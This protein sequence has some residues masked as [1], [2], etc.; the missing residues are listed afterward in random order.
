MA[1][2]EHSKLEAALRQGLE[3]QVPDDVLKAGLVRVAELQ[4]EEQK[5][6]ADEKRARDEVIAAARAT[7]SHQ[8]KSS[9]LPRDGS[10]V[11]LCGLREGQGPC[12]YPPHC[13]LEPYNGR[14]GRVA[15]DPIP[16]W[17]VKAISSTVSTAPDQLVCVH[18]GAK[19]SDEDRHN[20]LWLMVPLGSIEVQ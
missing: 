12:G 15:R 4:E 10:L 13:N 11:K 3:A 9:L 20:G 7:A 8:W 19:C 1:S 5:K 14:M 2:L 18:V 17:R 6:L 16:A